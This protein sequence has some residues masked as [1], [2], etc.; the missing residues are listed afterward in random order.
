[1]TWNRKNSCAHRVHN[2]TIKL[3]YHFF[4]FY[5]VAFLSITVSS[6]VLQ[7]NSCFHFMP[8]ELPLLRSFCNV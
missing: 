2:L 1:M 3:S 5:S 8:P 4:L 7:G 6:V